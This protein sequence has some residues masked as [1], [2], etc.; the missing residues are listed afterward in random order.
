MITVAFEFIG[1]EPFP[2]FLILLNSFLLSF[3]KISHLMWLNSL[4]N[5]NLLNDNFNKKLKTSFPKWRW[6]NEAT[7]ECKSG[8]F[9]ECNW[10]TFYFSF[11]RRRRVEICFVLMENQ[12]IW[13]FCA[14]H[15]VKFSWKKVFLS[16]FC[17]ATHSRLSFSVCKQNYSI[18]REFFMLIVW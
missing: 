3:L 8:L 6:E 1:L 14:F 18:K 5:Y 4:T 15:L 16:S 17:L 9:A 12:N 2:S 10:E 7:D 11:S 13:I